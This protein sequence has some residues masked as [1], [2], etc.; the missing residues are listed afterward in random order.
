MWGTGDWGQMTYESLY[1]VN[2]RSRKHSEAGGGK[3]VLRS[4]PGLF[5]STTAFQPGLSG[6]STPSL[7]L[8]TGLSPNLPHSL[9]PIGPASH[10]LWGLWWGGLL[11]WVDWWWGLCWQRKGKLVQPGGV[12]GLAG[13]VLGATGS[14]S[15]LP[16][17][18]HKSHLTL[19]KEVALLLLLQKGRV[20]PQ[21]AFLV[22]VLS[23]E[24]DT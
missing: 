12:S 10:P 3:L 23:E 16:I 21:T 11:W 4:C 14:F 1:I 22:F 20:F 15:A 17:I 9:G 7:A 13:Q 5:P 19:W 24:A 6:L 2:G 18:C 8:H